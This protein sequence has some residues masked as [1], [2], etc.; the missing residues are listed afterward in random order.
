MTARGKCLEALADARDYVMKSDRTEE[1][2]ELLFAAMEIVRVFIDEGT[3]PW[4]ALWIMMG[5]TASCVLMDNEFM[6]L[7]LALEKTVSEVRNV[8][9]AEIIVSNKVANC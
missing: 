6:N 2:K 1:E 7:T 8:R 9:F 3:R 5:I 4:L